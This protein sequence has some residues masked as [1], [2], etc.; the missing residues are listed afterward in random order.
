MIRR[1]SARLFSTTSWPRPARIG[2]AAA[3]ALG[4]WA[5]GS[6]AVSIPSLD[7]D[8]A[9]TVLRFA[10]AVTCA[11]L[12]MQILWRPFVPS[13]AHLRQLCIIGLL[14]PYAVMIFVLPP[15]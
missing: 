12:A 8:P 9:W 3:C 13:L 11:L 14:L 7:S 2:A 15:F 4:A 5:A 6:S 1:V 10:V